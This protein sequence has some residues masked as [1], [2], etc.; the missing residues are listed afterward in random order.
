[1]RGSAGND[2]RSTESPLGVMG[3][4]LMENDGVS[5]VRQKHPGTEQEGVLLAPLMNHPRQTAE[6]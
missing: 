6:F 5:V 2:T 1:M 4:W 3:A